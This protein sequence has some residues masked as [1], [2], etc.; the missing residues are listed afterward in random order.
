MMIPRANIIPLQDEEEVEMSLSVSGNKVVVWCLL[1][2][3]YVAFIILRY[4]CEHVHQESK[5]LILLYH[6]PIKN[7]LQSISILQSS[8]SIYYLYKHEVLTLFLL[9]LHSTNNNFQKRTSISFTN[10]A[11]NNSSEYLFSL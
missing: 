1:F 4:P 2:Q 11:Q 5:A 7:K 9:F 3:I 8:I 6:S 10:S